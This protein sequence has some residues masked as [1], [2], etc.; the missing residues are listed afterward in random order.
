[1]PTNVAPSTN[2]K[3]T[4]WGTTLAILLGDYLLTK[5]VQLCAFL[6]DDEVSTE[7]AQAVARVCRQGLQITQ[8]DLRDDG[9]QKRHL[10]WICE[11]SRAVF[12]LPC[13]IGG[14]VGG[15]SREHAEQL[16]Q[17]GLDLG[18]AWHI[19]DELA[20]ADGSRD[21]PALTT[22]TVGN[23]SDLTGTPLEDAGDSTLCNGDGRS[24]ALHLAQL[25][26]ES[27]LGRLESLPANE[28]VD[29]FRRLAM[30]AGARAVRV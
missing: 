22:L 12:A 24:V 26:A 30:H 16:A 1:V 15:L 29:A 17:A 7:V 6:E 9:A 18:V 11:R 8:L 14:L 27:A 23:T 13:L 2:G 3:G 28:A 21:L 20:V 19:T 10:E 4:D 25:H 5:A